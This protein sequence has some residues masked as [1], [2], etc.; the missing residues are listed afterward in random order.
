MLAVVLIWAADDSLRS[1]LSS[2][3]DTS[4]D[5]AGCRLHTGCIHTYVHVQKKYSHLSYV[6]YTINTWA[7]TDRFAKSYYRR[8]VSD[9]DILICTCASSHTET[10]DTPLLYLKHARRRWQTFSSHYCIV[11]SVLPELTAHANG[12]YARH[13]TVFFRLGLRNPRKLQPGMWLIKQ[14][15]TLPMRSYGKG[16]G[17]VIPI[18]QTQLWKNKLWEWEGNR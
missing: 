18:T 5:T 10:F 13:A 7:Q 1:A 11:T 8:I 9:I 16:T 4:L 14:S 3:K 17:I 15:N 6:M 12:H 2:P